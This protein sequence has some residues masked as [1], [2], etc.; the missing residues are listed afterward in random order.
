M[1]SKMSR[2]PLALL[3][4]LAMVFT[5]S[6]PAFTVKADAADTAG[7]NLAPNG[8]FEVNGSDTTNIGLNNV[9]AWGGGLAA[10]TDVVHSGN[11][12]LCMTA[13]P[14]DGAGGAIKPLP[15]KPDTTYMMT[16]WALRASGSG[17]LEVSPQFVNSGV[18]VG[19]Q[20]SFP[21]N[22]QWVQSTITFTTPDFANDYYQI[23]VYASYN[24]ADGDTNSVFYVDDLAV[25]ELYSGNIVTKTDPL[26]LAGNSGDS[27][28]LSL[29]PDTTYA[30]SASALS[31]DGTGKIQLY[32]RDSSNS[33]LAANEFT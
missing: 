21:G 25:Y 31:A 30:L 16:V 2:K 4:A 18:T 14:A 6:L 13:T 22:W 1:W 33:D 26:S 5:I 11:Q 9:N 8:G 20:L 23:M 3:L 29:A 12:S 27:Q 7:V 28:D 32:V 10:S 15:L 19:N 24:S 17:T